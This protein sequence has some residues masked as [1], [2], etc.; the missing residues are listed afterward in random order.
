MRK[1][2]LLVAVLAMVLLAASPAVAQPIEFVEGGV[3]I[4]AEGTGSLEEAPITGLFAVPEFG[5]AAIAGGDALVS[6]D[7][8]FGGGAFV[9]GSTAIGGTA[10]DV[11]L[12]SGSLCFDTTDFDLCP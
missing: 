4:I 10:G 9:D 7:P 8:T 2:Q 3:L 11:F 12:Q 6:A 5:A 1:L